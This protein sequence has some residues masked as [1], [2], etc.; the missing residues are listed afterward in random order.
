[1]I[2]IVVILV[3]STTSIKHTQQVCALP[4]NLISSAK[5]NVLNFATTLKIIDYGYDD[6]ENWIDFLIEVET[7]MF[8][9]IGNSS[10]AESLAIEREVKYNYD[11]K[12]NNYSKRKKTA[13]D[14]FDSDE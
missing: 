8:G 1:M 12:K 7:K 9:L 13:S 4:V 14:L 10:L 11:G 6:I 5:T 3:E 2:S